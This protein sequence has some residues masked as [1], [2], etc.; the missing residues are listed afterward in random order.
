MDVFD[1]LINVRPYKQA[2][3]KEKALE[4]IISG[5]DLQFDKDVVEAFVN[6]I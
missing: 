2:F 1:A 6:L 4:I 5:K 3:T